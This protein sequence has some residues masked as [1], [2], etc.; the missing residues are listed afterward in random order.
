MAIHYPKCNAT[1]YTNAFR[2]SPRR[3]VYR[4]VRCYWMWIAPAFKW[5]TR[6]RA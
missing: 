2:I 5:K 3:N 6:E 4:C 1:D